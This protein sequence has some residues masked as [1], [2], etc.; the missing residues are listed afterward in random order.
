M[1]AYCVRG[2]EEVNVVKLAAFMLICLV[3]LAVLGVTL[4]HHPLGDPINDPKPNSIN[5]GP[6]VFGEAIDDP[7]PGSLRPS[8]RVFGDPIDDPKPGLW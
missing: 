8:Y 3:S 7:K 2:T 1:Y 6:R 4:I 5:P